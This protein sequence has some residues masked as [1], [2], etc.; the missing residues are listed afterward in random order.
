[1]NALGMKLR[2]VLGQSCP[3]CHRGDLFINKNPYKIEN[4]DRMHAHCS[5]CGLHYEMEPGFFQGAMYVSY[6]LG[7]ALSVAVVIVNVLIGFN[8]LIYFVAN[9]VVLILLAPFIFRWSRALYMNFFIGY[10]ARLAK[11][12][13]SSD[14]LI[15][16]PGV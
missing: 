16:T 4:W 2:S 7:V 3:R 13:K 10:D 9:T 15:Q 12:A 6:A 1:M 8:P 11:S 14:S 5:H